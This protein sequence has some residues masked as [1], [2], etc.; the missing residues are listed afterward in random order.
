MSKESKAAI[1][2]TAYEDG[3][4][5]G[6]HTHPENDMDCWIWKGTFS[7]GGRNPS[8]MLYG[9]YRSAVKWS[10]RRYNGAISAE[11]TIHHVCHNPSCVNPNH[12]VLMKAD[13]HL[14]L[15]QYK[16]LQSLYD[17]ETDI[18]EL[19]YRRSLIKVSDWWSKA[20]PLATRLFWA[21]LGWLVI[22]SVS[23]LLANGDIAKSAWTM[24]S[25]AVFYTFLNR[26]NK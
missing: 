11:H 8:M 20:K 12:L 24:A 22:V 6:N 16:T 4:F 19:L 14:R 13:E 9:K 21:W 5:G 17:T 10:Y 23:V 1:D 26:R 3:V 15:H 7:S 18:P 25:V 2:P